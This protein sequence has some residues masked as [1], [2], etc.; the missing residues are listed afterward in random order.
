VTSNEETARKLSDVWVDMYVVSIMHR[1][2]LATELDGLVTGNPGGPVPDIE[3]VRAFLSAICRGAL[4][5]RPEPVKLH[6]SPLHRLF[7]S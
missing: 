3:A 2:E 5:D 6:R 1:P 4:T 7:R